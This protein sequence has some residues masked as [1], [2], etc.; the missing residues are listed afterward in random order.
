MDTEF[1]TI[2]AR[3]YEDLTIGDEIVGGLAND[4]FY[5]VSPYI[6]TTGASKTLWK[7]LDIEND[8]IIN[9]SECGAT[10]CQNL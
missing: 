4:G 7:I 5:A 10:Q 3:D 6:A 9:I 2:P 8:I 1:A